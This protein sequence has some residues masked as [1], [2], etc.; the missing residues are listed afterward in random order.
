MACFMRKLRQP[1]GFIR[2][3]CE[4]GVGSTKQRIDR[5]ETVRGAGRAVRAARRGSGQTATAVCPHDARRTKFAA[6]YGA[7]PL[8][9]RQHP[10]H[11]AAAH[12]AQE[13]RQLLDI[14]PRRARSGQQA[15]KPGNAAGYI[16]IIKQQPHIEDTALCAICLIL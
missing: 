7:H 14:R 11:S 1:A 13:H 6:R 16:R 3:G 15:A 8:D 9:Q 10:L 5:D 4:Q 2:P 12:S